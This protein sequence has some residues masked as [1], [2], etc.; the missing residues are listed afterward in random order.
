VTQSKKY[1]GWKNYETWSIALLLNQEGLVDYFASEVEDLKSIRSYKAYIKYL[2]LTK[3]SNED[4]VRYLNNALGYKELTEMLLDARKTAI[5]CE[6]F[7]K[8]GELLWDK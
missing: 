4:G 6:N 2:G 1:Y 8:Q 3:E 5:K 7:L